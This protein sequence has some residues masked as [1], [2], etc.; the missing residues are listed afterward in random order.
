MKKC[1]RNECNSMSARRSRE[2]VL[3]RN[4]CELSSELYHKNTTFPSSLTSMQEDG[5]Y[6]AK[7]VYSYFAIDDA[8]ARLGRKGY[9]QQRNALFTLSFRQRHRHFFQT[10]E[11]TMLNTYA[12]TSRDLHRSHFLRNTV[13][14]VTSI[15]VIYI[16]R[17]I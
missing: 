17:F 16:R 12:T 5:F 9:T 1:R 2:L 3:N 6:F 8:D 10:G 4:S 7:T 11:K 15:E 13:V 14:S